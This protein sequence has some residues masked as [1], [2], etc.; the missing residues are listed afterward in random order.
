MAFHK[1]RLI[2]SSSS[3]HSLAA[4]GIVSRGVAVKGCAA[5]GGNNASVRFLMSQ[6]RAVAQ[7]KGGLGCGAAP[8]SPPCSVV[9]EALGFRASTEGGSSSV[10]SSCP[11]I[12]AVS[13]A[14]SL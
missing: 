7:G 1:D 13:S 3:E 2:A 11:S 14:T 8:I 5:E 6:S 9:A 12:G 10:G 4:A